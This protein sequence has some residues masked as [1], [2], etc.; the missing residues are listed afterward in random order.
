MVGDTVAIELI[1]AYIERWFKFVGREGEVVQFLEGV[2][3]KCLNIVFISL[4]K[5][6]DKY[7]DF[8]CN[9]LQIVSSL[10]KSETICF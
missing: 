9:R 8:L 5:T 7:R 1:G 4:M 10:I 3:A 2:F 6:K